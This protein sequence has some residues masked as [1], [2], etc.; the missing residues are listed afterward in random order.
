MVRDGKSACAQVQGLDLSQEFIAAALEMRQSG[1]KSYKVRT[2]SVCVC[3]WEGIRREKSDSVL[4][5]LVGRAGS[6]L[7]TSCRLSSPDPSEQAKILKQPRCHGR[8]LSSRR[9]IGGW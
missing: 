2:R 3:V 9:I 7:L 8:R 6:L 4:D 1:Y 5:G